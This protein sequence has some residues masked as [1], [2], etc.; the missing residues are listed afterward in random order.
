MI[1]SPAH[2][3]YPSWRD[4]ASSEVRGSKLDLLDFVDDCGSAYIRSSWQLEV[5]VDG[6]VYNVVFNADGQNFDCNFVEDVADNIV[7]VFHRVVG[8]HGADVHRVVED[9]CVC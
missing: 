4:V 5:E 2:C 8:V 1:D 6:G 3:A 7:I 9:R